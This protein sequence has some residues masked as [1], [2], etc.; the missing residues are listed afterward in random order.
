MKHFEIAECPAVPA[1]G[2]SPRPSFPPT[3][4]R[5]GQCRALGCMMDQRVAGICIL[6]KFS[7]QA[8][9]TDAKRETLT[10]NGHDRTTLKG[11]AGQTFAQF[12]A[13][14]DVGLPIM[15]PDAPMSGV[16]LPAPLL[17]RM[18]Q[19]IA[20]V[21][22][23]QIDC[24]AAAKDAF[25][26]FGL[27]NRAERAAS[28]DAIANEIEARSAAITDIGCQKPAGPDLR[29]IHRPGGGVRRVDLSVR[30]CHLGFRHG[31]QGVHG[32]GQRPFHPGTAWIVV[33]GIRAALTRPGLH[34]AVFPHTRPRPPRRQ[35][36]APSACRHRRDGPAHAVR[37][38]RRSL[39]TSLPPPLGSKIPDAGVH[40]H[41]CPSEDKGAKALASGSRPGPERR[42]RAPI[43]CMRTNPRRG[44]GDPL[45][46]VEPLQ[47]QSSGPVGGAVKRFVDAHHQ[48]RDPAAKDHPWLRQS[49]P[50]PFR[51]GGHMANSRTASMGCAARSTS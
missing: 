35:A 42:S 5:A 13:V 4:A 48:F 50:I 33:D 17:V 44:C 15:V 24:A 38:P 46:T 18:A 51:S 2:P 8:L 14:S 21:A 39:Q 43:S 47:Y 22:L 30:V 26:S 36:V 45:P 25:D 31:G 9:L 7:E 40:A 28:P 29:T 23:L 27:T 32:G 6:A 41:P 1:T 11:T 19:G 16:D 20:Q 49:P 12:R 10:R 34:P 37:P 3:A